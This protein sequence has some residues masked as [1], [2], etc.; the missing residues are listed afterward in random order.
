MPSIGCCLLLELL[1]YA[2][3]YLILEFNTQYLLIWFIIGRVSN[4]TH[5]YESVD[6]SV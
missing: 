3:C 4:A 1:S 6:E 5:K 2:F